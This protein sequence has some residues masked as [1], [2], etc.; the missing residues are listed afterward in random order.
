MSPNSLTAQ[1]LFRWFCLNMLHSRIKFPMVCDCL[2]TW[3]WILP[4]CLGFPDTFGADAPALKPQPPGPANVMATNPAVQQIGPGLFALD[5]IRLDQRQQSL[6]F[7]AL[8]NM[9][10]GNLEYL[11]VTATG[12]THESLLRTEAKP[13][14]IQLAFLLLGAQ[15]TTNALPE[16][17]AKALPGDRVVIELSWKLDGRVLR[18]PAEKFITDQKARGPMSLGYW[19]YNGS[20]LRQDGFA[21]QLDGSIV[22]LITDADA[23]INN[24]RPGREDDDNWLAR[25]TDLPPLNSPVEVT[26]RLSQGAK[27]A[28]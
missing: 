15:G 4:G 19:I 13:Y 16:D 10:E 6:S 18:F 11:I 27:Q 23:L 14:Q 9:K 12:K 2:W 20:R 28:K 26:I 5:G 3:C 17:P 21:A 7:G 8:V 25:G 24:P 22:S 1:R